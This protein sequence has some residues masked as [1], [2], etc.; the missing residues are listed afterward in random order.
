MYEN[1]EMLQRNMKILVVSVEVSPFAKT[2]GLAD[3]A[4]SLPK[5]LASLGNDV[6]VVMPRFRGME[7]TK[8]ISDFP[9]Q[10]GDYRATCIVRQGELAN[11]TGADQHSVPVYF[12][13][14]Y[15]YFDRDGLYMHHDDGERF[16]FFCRAVLEMLPHIDFQPD[17]IHCND[18]HTGP[19]CAMLN[20]DYFRDQALYSKMATVFTI[21]NLKYQGHY[22]PQV[23]PLM[24]LPASYFSPDK[25]EFW[26][27]VNFMK[28]GLVFADVINTVS[29]TYAKEIQ[30]AEYG[31]GLDGLLRK[32]A[33]D[34][35][36]IVNGISY[37]EFNPEFDSRIC[38]NFSADN[39]GDK[40]EN[41]SALQRERGLPV[42]D[43]PLF[44]LV[45]RLVDQKGLELIEANAQQLLEQD[46]QMVILGEGDP[47]YENLFRDLQ[48]Q[49]PNKVAV[50]I[51]FNASLAQ[52]IYAGADLFLMPS[53]YEPCGLGQMISMR[54]GTIPIVRATGGLADTVVEYNLDSGAGNGFSFAEYAPEPFMEAINRGL[55]LYWHQRED[56]NNLVQRV[57][58][59]DNSW[60][61]AAVEYME[62]F[63][64]AI[65][66]RRQYCKHN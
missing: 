57:L 21:H 1:K 28:A 39:F 22:A 36:G 42:K 40:R 45:S 46:V 25:L 51:G 4:G 15:H 5:A 24:G 7:K 19:I 54:Y 8:A 60:N 2:G 64:T 11:K 43:V 30:T 58:Q 35:F 9:V 50:F 13:D 17:V 61:K 14:N 20:T 18:W 29:R 26:G 62:V 16:I 66:K 48:Q 32:R 63:D 49:Y 52:R 56:W 37:E 23:L 3:V 59:I 34:L 12:I 38:C 47:R 53:R 31:E 41:K 27:Q 6:R 10:M 33:Q 44:G 55:N 65:S